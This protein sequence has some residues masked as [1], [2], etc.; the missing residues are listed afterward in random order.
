MIA[1]RKT[2]KY[3]FANYIFIL[4]GVLSAQE[5]HQFQYINPKPASVMVSGETNI[6]LAH[7]SYINPATV[8]PSLIFVEGSTSGIHSGELLLSDDNR[9]LVFNP[10]M[11]FVSNE[12]VKVILGDG[13]RTRSGNSIPGFSFSFRTAK[14]GID[15]IPEEAFADLTL[16]TEDQDIGALKGSRAVASLPP[17]PITID[18]IDNPSDGYIFLATWDR[19]MPALYGNFIFILDK[20]GVIVDSLRVEGAPYDFQVQPNGLLSFALGD[21]AANVPLP[22]EELQHMV[23]D[24]NLAVV[25]SFKM[26]NGY[27][28]DFHEFKMLPNGHVMMMSYHTITYDMSTLVDG[29]KPDASL[30]INIIQEQDLDKNVVFEWRN[31]DYIPITDSDLDLT[32]SRIN[33]GTLN[34]FDVDDDGNILTSFRNHSEIMKISRETGEVMWRMGGPRGEFNYVGEHEENAPYY[35]ARQHNIQRQPNGNITLFDNGQ[36]HQP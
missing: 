13:L 29:G 10:D 1:F 5:S 9:T 27:I 16:F 8:S 17:P 20:N 35:H 15:R 6:I 36:F 21:F 34:A 23:L 26:K 11:A 3:L 2:L 22:G 28:T 18:S 19:N 24:E 12:E 7:S 25:D 4:S 30:V 32:A 14:A 31:I 33:Y